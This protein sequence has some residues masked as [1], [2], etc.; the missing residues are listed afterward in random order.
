MTDLKKLAEGTVDDISAKLSSLSDDDLKTLHDAEEDGAGRTTLL[1]AIDR[2]R[3]SRQSKEPT[4]TKPT[5]TTRATKADSDVAA[6]DPE[7]GE[8]ARNETM[9]PGP[10]RSEGQTGTVSGAKRG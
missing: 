5:P 9:K 10:L 7:E 3:D 1:G 4:T 6:Y 2:E 8:R